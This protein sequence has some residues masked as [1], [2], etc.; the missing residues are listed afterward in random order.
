LWA[1]NFVFFSGNNNRGMLSEKKEK[2]HGKFIKIK[3]YKKFKLEE[4]NG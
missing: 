4:N 2:K 3:H 1:N